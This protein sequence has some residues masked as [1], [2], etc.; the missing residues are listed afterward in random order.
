MTQHILLR[1]H[2]CSLIC[3]LRCRHKY[4]SLQVLCKALLLHQAQRVLELVLHQAQRVLVLLLH[5]A[6]VS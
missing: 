5:Q 4:F 2:P 3:E 1:C 6:L